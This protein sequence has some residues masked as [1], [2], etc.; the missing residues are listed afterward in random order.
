MKTNPKK[1]ILQISHD[2]FYSILRNIPRG[3][4]IESAEHVFLILDGSPK[5]HRKYGRFLDRL[6]D[7]DNSVK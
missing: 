1:K 4:V 6:Y 2:E 5:G 3:I 7:N